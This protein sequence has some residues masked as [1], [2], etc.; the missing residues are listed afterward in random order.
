MDDAPRRELRF[1]DQ[2]Y[3]RGMDWYRKHFTGSGIS[4]EVSPR[5]LSHE[6]AATRMERD[7]PDC[8]LI[9]IFRDPVERAYSDY[10]THRTRGLETDSFDAAIE[11]PD[12][13][14]LYIETGYYARHLRR[15]YGRFSRSQVLPIIFDD[16][17]ADP[18]GTFEAVA[19]FVGADPTVVPDTVGSQVNVHVMF[20]SRRARR[21]AQRVPEPFRGAALRAVAA[22]NRKE[23][24][25]PPMS[26]G[27]QQRLRRHYQP[28]ITE[29]ASLLDRPLP[30]DT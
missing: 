25:R 28:Q 7:V 23:A 5:Y 6:A 24:G 9:F 3:A 13:R 2:N 8:R 22:V 1:F 27:T 16:L 15:F 19:A 10:W 17:A 30:W 14:Q 20:R 12:G 26:P 21:W 18:T 4:G 29:L 11:R